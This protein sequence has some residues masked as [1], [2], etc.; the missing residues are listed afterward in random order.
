[1]PKAQ[2]LPAAKTT[3]PNIPTFGVFATCDPRIDDA[4]RQRAINIIEMAADIIAYGVTMPDKTPALVAWSPVLVDG[5][6]Q[7]DIV[8]QQFRSYGV[9]ILVCTPDTWAFPQ[10][11]LISLLQQFP[12]DTPLNL[13][14]GNSG[15]KPG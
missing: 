2:R 4:S 12:A 13:T 9:N 1:M 7:A 6:V 10:L 14:C 15:P 3:K 8:A 5:E 11:S